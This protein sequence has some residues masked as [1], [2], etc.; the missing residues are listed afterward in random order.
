MDD[1]TAVKEAVYDAAVSV[2][3]QFVTDPHQHVIRDGDDEPEQPPMIAYQGSTRP[4]DDHM[5]IHDSRVLSVEQ[6]PF[7]VVYGED[8]TLTVDLTVADTDADRANQIQDALANAYTYDG[9]VRDPSTFVTAADVPVDAVSASDS[10]PLN[11]DY[12]VGGSLGVTVEFTRRYRHSDLEDPPVPA[13][14]VEQEYEVGDVVYV[15]DANG[16]S[17]QSSQ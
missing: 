11:R 7:D 13:T 9:R 5:G 12:R 4:N 1:T 8:R 3:R 15:T 6:S 14:T 17:V 10:S 16:V 2:M